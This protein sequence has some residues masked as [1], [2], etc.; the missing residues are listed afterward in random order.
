MPVEN[1]GL[2][3]QSRCKTYAVIEVRRAEDNE[4]CGFVE[5]SSGGWQSLSVFGGHLASFADM[6]QAWDHVLSIGLASLAERWWFRE[7]STSEWQMVC[8]Q[9]ASPESVTLA[10]DYYSMPGVP[11][12]TISREQLNLTMELRLTVD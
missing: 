3:A 9:E 8:I 7:N 10:L 2:S 12:L 5:E 11:A 4:L 1:H 6:G